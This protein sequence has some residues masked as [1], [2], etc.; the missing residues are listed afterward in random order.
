M[1]S[2]TSHCTNLHVIAFNVDAMFCTVGH[3]QIFESIITAQRGFPMLLLIIINFI[4]HL[5]L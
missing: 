1:D 3:L 5:S 4:Y 2:T